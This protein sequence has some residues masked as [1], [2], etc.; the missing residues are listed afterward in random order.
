MDPF[1]DVTI[2]GQTFRLKVDTGKEYVVELAA[3]V[4]GIM[5]EVRRHSG[6]AASHRV[7]VMA[8]L[9]IADS[10]FQLR[11]QREGEVQSASQKVNH[12]IARSDQV[13]NG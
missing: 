4:E 3:Y 6:T 5:E 11:R 13:L 12:L 8:A 1:L 10:L 9:Q 7:A 2:Q